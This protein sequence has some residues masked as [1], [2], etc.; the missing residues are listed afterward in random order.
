MDPVFAGE[1]P[2]PI[3][4][5]VQ[6]IVAEEE[7]AVEAALTGDR[8]KVIQAMHISPMMPDKDRVPELVD[9]LLEANAQWLPQFKG[10]HSKRESFAAAK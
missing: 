4:P 7:L 9:E 5:M 10:K 1:V 8:D 2:H 6:Q 3:A